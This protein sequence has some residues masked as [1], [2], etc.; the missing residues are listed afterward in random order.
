LS[1][2]P[3]SVTIMS[4]CSNPPTAIPVTVPPGQYVQQLIDDHG[5]LRSVYISNQPYSDGSTLD[6]FQHNYY[7]PAQMQLQ[8]PIHTTSFPAQFPVPHSVPIANGLPQN[9][10]S[11]QPTNV[12]QPEYHSYVQQNQSGVVDDRNYI[13]RQK[14][15]KKY[16]RKRP[17]VYTN[18][19]SN[20]RR[21]Q[22]FENEH[23]KSNDSGAVLYENENG[24]GDVDHD[25]CGSV[26]PPPTSNG[27][28][29]EEDVL[30]AFFSTVSP[31]TVDNIKA[32]S[33][34]ITCPPLEFSQLD[35]SQLEKHADLKESDLEY[36]V[37]CGESA[38]KQRIFTAGTAPQLT[39]QLV[40]LRPNTE[41][42]VW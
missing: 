14:L 20:H 4:N 12:Y 40:E 5:V 6:S 33:V 22:E 42:L 7:V 29:S 18:N 35:Y 21:Y 2:G 17:P 32:N 28:E 13:A 10:Y 3:A 26:S 31:V 27:I 16:E 37:C 15:K 39:L 34:T 36:F 41:Y 9:G 1:E 23:Q 19:T 11:S 24:S 38:D 8:M 30:A 25:G